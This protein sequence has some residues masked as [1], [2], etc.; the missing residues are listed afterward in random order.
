MENQTNYS[1]LKTNLLF[2]TNQD[3]IKLLKKDLKSKSE[4]KHK[5]FH[6]NFNLNC[7]KEFQSTKNNFKKFET[8]E[9][10]KEK[11]KI[12]EINKR[13]NFFLKKKPE[14]SQK[15]VLDFNAIN[16]LNE[17]S[18]K[19][20][21]NSFYKNRNIKTANNTSYNTNINNNSSLMNNLNATSRTNFLNANSNNN[22]NNNLSNYGTS[23]F[24]NAS[25]ANFFL[26][27]T[28]NLSKFNSIFKSDFPEYIPRNIRTANI[29]AGNPRKARFQS[30]DCSNNSILNNLNN[31]INSDAK[32]KL[33][34]VNNLNKTHK[35]SKYEKAVENTIMTFDDNKNNLNKNFNSNFNS[36]SYNNSFYSKNDNNF[37]TQ[38]KFDVN[39]LEKE[40]NELVKCYINCKDGDL[41]DENIKSFSHNELL[42]KLQLKS[43][44]HPEEE[45]FIL[46]FLRKNKNLLETS[47]LYNSTFKKFSAIEKV[48]VNESSYKNPVSALRKL[49]LNKD[50]FNNVM[51]FRQKKQIDSYLDIFDEQQDKARKQIQMG[52]VKQTDMKS[53]YSNEEIGEVIHPIDLLHEKNDASSYQINKQVS[54]DQVLNFNLELFAS[55]Y[56]DFKMKPWARSA[57]TLNMEGNQM[58]MFGGISGEILYQVWVCDCKS[59]F[60]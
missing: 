41:D 50:I 45:K 1:K 24:F 26:G 6:K 10:F 44:T 5:K 25:G 54:R 14:E 28:N 58:I 29:M 33:D 37:K 46:D 7:D 55:N 39:K 8:L 35:E 42:N 43:L 34:L 12:D 27:A 4:N 19:D 15:G 3:N 20:A 17:K 38:K 56:S 60:I 22:N 51:D 40:M 32:Q 18:E 21:I 53:F 36:S 30:G 48:Y 9:E 47:E 2:A 59:N 16:N 49:K 52:K 11:L 23:N 13:L 31:K 57:F